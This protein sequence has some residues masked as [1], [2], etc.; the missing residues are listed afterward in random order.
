MRPPVD[1][2]ENGFF[3]L[4]CNGKSYQ[5][6]RHCPHRGGRL[7][8]G[9]VNATRGTLTCPLHKSVFRLEDGK[10]LSGPEC[11]A[12]EVSEIKNLSE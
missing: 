1:Y 10:Q 3:V 5:V 8:H 4:L 7:E 12:L 2:S 11:G 6:P 9:E